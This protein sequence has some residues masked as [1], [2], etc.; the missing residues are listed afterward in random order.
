MLIIISSLI[1]PSILIR[2]LV[3]KFGKWSDP[4][5]C[6]WSTVI[7]SKYLYNIHIIKI[8]LCLKHYLLIFSKNLFM[9]QPSWN[10]RKVYIIP[11]KG[12]QKSTIHINTGIIKSFKIVQLPWQP[13]CIQHL[14]FTTKM[15]TTWIMVYHSFKFL[16][17]RADISLFINYFNLNVSLLKKVQVASLKKKFTSHYP[18]LLGRINFV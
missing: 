4:D 2:Y 14:A 18:L 8:K 6:Y 11:W 13:V 3:Q 15:G 9:R 1:F 7:T 12:L 10:K 17:Q 16:H 5:L